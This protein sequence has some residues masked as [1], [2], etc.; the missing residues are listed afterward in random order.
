MR[1]PGSWRHPLDDPL[2]VAIASVVL[3]LLCRGAALPL[4]LALPLSLGLALLLSQRRPGG[5]RQERL[6]DR[7]VSAGIEA[8]LERSHQL[9]G[10][11][12]LLLE[13][14]LVRLEDPSHL[15]A[16]GQVQLCCERLAALPGQIAER[17]ELLESG[18]G[19]LL[20][21]AD[22]EQRLRREE[23]ALS[24]EASPT[25]RIE[26]RRLVQ[27]LRRNLEAA[28]L[29]MDERDGRL[30]ALSTRLESIEGGLRQLKRQLEQQ[31][32][33]GAAVATAMAAAIAPLAGALDQ[34]EQLLN[35]GY[36]PTA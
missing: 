29:G 31:W 25:L 21:V 6:Q 26:R 14:A 4:L 12:R 20:P 18:G 8:A 13:E 30:L 24:R 7:R 2:A 23:Q 33:S 22:L 15:E 27:Q 35:A 17:R 28:R 5:S 11:A 34:I 1:F 10:Q 16:L 3:V 36:Q 19:V 9:A 32:P